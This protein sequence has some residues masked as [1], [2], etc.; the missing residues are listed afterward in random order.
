VRRQRARKGVRCS[1]KR[2][3]LG[4]CIVG[5]PSMGEKWSCGVDGKGGRGEDFGGVG[6]VDNATSLV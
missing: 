1:R 2:L 5:V 4:N 6:R 3:D